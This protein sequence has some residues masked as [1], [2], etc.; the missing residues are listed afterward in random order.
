MAGVRILSLGSRRRKSWRSADLVLGD[1]EQ[2]RLALQKG[3]QNDVLT[4]LDGANANLSADSPSGDRPCAACDR[5]AGERRA[6]CLAKRNSSVA[7]L[8]A[9]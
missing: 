3:I 2:A 9:T 6:F 8:L 1:T 5:S 4:W 7:R